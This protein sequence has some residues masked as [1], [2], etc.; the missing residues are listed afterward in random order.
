MIT[1]EP[2]HEFSPDFRIKNTASGSGLFT[3]GELNELASLIKG[4]EFKYS[5]KISEAV[6]D[7]SELLIFISMNTGYEKSI[8]EI[9]DEIELRIKTILKHLEN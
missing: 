7:I 2:R 1:I 4:E 9:Y 5:P 3:K 6:R 8:N